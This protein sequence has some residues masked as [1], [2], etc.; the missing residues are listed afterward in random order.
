[1]LVLKESANSNHKQITIKVN[2]PS[3]DGLEALI[4][5]IDQNSRGGH[6]FRVTVDPKNE[7][8]K[9][10]WIDGDGSFRISDIEVQQEEDKE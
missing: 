2:D 4:K 1:M 3:I 5:Y 9:D 8:E 6:S 10:F 7:L